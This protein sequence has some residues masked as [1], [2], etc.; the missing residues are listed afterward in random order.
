MVEEIFANL[1]RSFVEGA[2]KKPMSFYFSLGDTKKTVQLTAESCIVSDGRVVESA[3]C[4]CKTSPEFFIK[5]WD[6]GYRP[7]LKD[8]LSGTIKSNNPNALQ[9]FLNGFGK[10]P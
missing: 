5:I 8:F 6:E 7:G 2:V 10:G 3:D 1:S 4:V 9:D